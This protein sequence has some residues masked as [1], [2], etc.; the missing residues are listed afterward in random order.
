MPFTHALRRVFISLHFDIIYCGFNRLFKF[1]M[2]YDIVV[3]TRRTNEKKQHPSNENNCNDF[4]CSFQTSADTLKYKK[5]MISIQQRDR[6]TV[7][8]VELKI[9]SQRK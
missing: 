7:D 2:K 3:K 5:T 9:G 4:V 1:I 8:R 6:D